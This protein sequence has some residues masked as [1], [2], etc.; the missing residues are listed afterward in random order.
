MLQWRQFYQSRTTFFALNEEEGTALR[1]FFVFL[2]TD[3]DTCLC[4]RQ[5]ADSV[6]KKAQ[7]CLHLLRKLRTFNISKDILT[8]VYRSP[9]ESTLKMGKS[10]GDITAT[11]SVFI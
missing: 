6:Y 10:M 4:F 1:H 7:Q 5:H 3:I 8:V 2:R 9:I 11:P